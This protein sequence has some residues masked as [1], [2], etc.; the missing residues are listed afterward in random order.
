MLSYGK[1]LLLH[2]FDVSRE[3]SPD[4]FLPSPLSSSF[5]Q[6]HAYSVYSEKEVI[7]ISL[8]SPLMP[9]HKTRLSARLGDIFSEE[10]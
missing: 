1:M 8:N 9:R 4:P 5:A 3:F 2:P 10:V 7:A 6:L